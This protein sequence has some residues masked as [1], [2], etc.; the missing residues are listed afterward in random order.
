MVFDEQQFPFSCT[1]LAPFSVY[2][3]L[4]NTD[5]DQV[6]LGALPA[7]VSGS[8][9]P[10]VVTPGTGSAASSATSGGTAAPVEA[11]VVHTPAAGH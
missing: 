9:G 3:F 8:A 10:S 1:S 11:S 2:D 5:V 6:I 4:D 7:A